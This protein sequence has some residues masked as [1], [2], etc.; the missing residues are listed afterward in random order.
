MDAP[1]VITVEVRWQKAAFPGVELDLAQ[2]PAAFKA[3]LFSLTGVPPERQKIVGFRG[4]L[5]K[6]DADWAAAGARAGLRVTMMGTA[7]AAPAAPAAAARFVEDLPPEERDTTGLAKYGAGLRNLGNTCYMNSTLQCLYAVP[8][9]R[10]ALGGGAPA[11]AP[12]PG[13]DAAAAGL[14]AA[15]RG[16]FA[17]LAASPQPV[18]PLEFVLA[19]RRAYPQFDQTGREGGHLQQDAEECWSALLAALRAR[20]PEGPAG[21][22]AVRRLFGVPTAATL[23]CDE[24]GEEVRVEEE[25][26]MLKCNITS[27]VNHL[28]DGLRLALVADRERTSAALGATAAFRGAART[29]AL[30]PYLTVQMVRFFYKQDVQQKAKI[31]R[32]VTFPLVLDALEFCAPELAAELAAPREAARAAE[33]AAAGLAKR[34]KVAAAAV[35]GGDAAADAPAAAAPAAAPA[36]AAEAEAAAGAAAAAAAAAHA[37]AP[38]GRYELAGVLTHKGRSADSGHYVAWV[39]QSDASWIQF[40]DEEMIPRKEEEVLALAGGGDW[41]MAYLLLYRAQ[42]VPG[43][44]AGAAAP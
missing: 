39:R 21:A 16:L 36:A 38:T 42:R 35:A 9:L 2:P 28:A 1:G 12:P 40:D 17:D 31:L 24:T 30:P 33:D 19:L 20:T 7:D 41:H 25:A 14:A 4:G 44:P 26:L 6:D 11:G 15:A 10:A 27:E 8:E 5:L 23:R 13:D 34:Q 32:K 29:T 3:A 43:A 18:P 22:S 37:G